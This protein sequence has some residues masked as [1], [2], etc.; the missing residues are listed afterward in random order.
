LHLL[1]Q[2]LFKLLIIPHLKFNYKIINFRKFLP[3]CMNSSDIKNFYEN[4]FDFILNSLFKID[5]L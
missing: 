1:S 5:P 3:F 2:L 4:N